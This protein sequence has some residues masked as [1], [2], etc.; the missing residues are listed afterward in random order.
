MVKYLSYYSSFLNNFLVK[1]SQLANICNNTKIN[2][3][4]NIYILYL[5]ITIICLILKSLNYIGNINN[6]K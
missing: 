2:E 1:K 6:H 4:D 5:F 3:T